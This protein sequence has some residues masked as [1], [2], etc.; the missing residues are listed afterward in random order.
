MGVLRGNP[1]EV[2]RTVFFLTFQGCLKILEIF[3]VIFESFG[4]FSVR[5]LQPLQVLG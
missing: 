2:I 1:R 5:V 4:M 3:Q